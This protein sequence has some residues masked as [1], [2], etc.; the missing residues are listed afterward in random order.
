MQI[1]FGL[2]DH[3]ENRRGVEPEEQYQ[4]KIALLQAAERLGYSCYH[5]AEH[6][7]SPLDM[8][9]SPNVFLAAL[10][11]ATTR[12]HI[13]TMVYI[14]PLYNPVRLVQE[15]CMLDNL[16]GGRLEVGVGRGARA[17]EHEWFGVDPDEARPQN[18]E[19]LNVLVSAMT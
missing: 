5:I 10:A 14:L 15:I 6:H 7:L 1:E 3:F 12:L 17:V 16:S 9:P 19:M 11:Q 13:G 18:E 4:Q 2:W 8:A